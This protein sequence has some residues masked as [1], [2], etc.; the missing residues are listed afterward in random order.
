MVARVNRA[1]LVA[2]LGAGAVDAEQV[3]GQR[4]GLLKGT[5]QGV[6]AGEDGVDDERGGPGRCGLALEELPQPGPADSDSGIPG[7]VAR[8]HPPPLDARGLPRRL[9]VALPRP[10][11][12]ALA[13]ERE[14]GPDVVGLGVLTAVTG[15]QRRSSWDCRALNRSGSVWAI[16]S[17][18]SPV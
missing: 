15:T 13:D 5:A 4:V 2:I 3:D 11:C 8:D 18:S 6:V 12:A 7:L 14:V 1:A 17:R 16:S 9:F 10:I